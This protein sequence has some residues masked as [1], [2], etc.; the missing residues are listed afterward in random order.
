M[1]K[2]DRCGMIEGHV[3]NLGT[4]SVCHREPI[5]CIK[6][7]RDEIDRLRRENAELKSEIT[8]LR[9]ECAHQRAADSDL[10]FGEDN[11]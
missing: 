5:T 7:L 9:I 6:H 10:K 2:C 11:A 3:L 4:G 8:C 1:K